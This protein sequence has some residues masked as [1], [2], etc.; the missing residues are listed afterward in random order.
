MAEQAAFRAGTAD[1]S[2]PLV[3]GR[4]ELYFSLTINLVRALSGG[5]QCVMRIT[6]VLF[7]MQP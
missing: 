6:L 2:L 3:S 5:R 4:S 1:F 7:G